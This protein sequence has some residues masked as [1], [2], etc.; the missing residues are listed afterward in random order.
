MGQIIWTNHLHQ[1]I[2]ERQIDPRLVDTAIRYPDQ[3]ISSRTTNSQKHIKSFGN[4]QIVA[5]VKRHGN[6]WIVTSVWKKSSYQTK[7]YYQKPLLER[8]VYNFIVW[9]EQLITGRSNR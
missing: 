1:R 4:Y 2:K 5:A 7:G 6:D 8:L 9:V 3:V